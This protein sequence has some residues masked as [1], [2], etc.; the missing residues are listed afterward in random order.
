MLSDRKQLLRDTILAVSEKI[1]ADAG[2]S[3][4]KAR[5]IARLA[6]CSVGTIYTVFS[7]VDDLILF[8]NERTLSRLEEQLKDYTPPQDTSPRAAIDWMVALSLIYLDFAA[9]NRLLWLALFEHRLE[10]GKTPPEWHVDRHKALFRFVEHPLEQV[11]IE[12]DPDARSLLARSLFSAVHGIVL[13]GLE[14]K[15]TTMSQDTLKQQIKIVV[16]ACIIGFITATRKLATGDG[17]DTL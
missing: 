7:D 5:D 14:E 2:L 13:L 16:S 11:M 10:T 17:S 8:V 1:I 9:N 4:L 3:A 6:G 12:T 15:I